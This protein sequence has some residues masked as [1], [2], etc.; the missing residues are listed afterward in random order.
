MLI[1]IPSHA[2]EQILRLSTDQSGLAISS[3]LRAADFCLSQ[4][5]LTVKVTFKM[6]PPHTTPQP[7]TFGESSFDC[8]NNDWGSSFQVGFDSSFDSGAM[9]DYRS[10]Q[11]QLKSRWS[12][13]K[14]APSES[15]QLTLKCRRR[16]RMFDS[17]SEARPKSPTSG[18]KAANCCSN[19]GSDQTLTCSRSANEAPRYQSVEAWCV[20]EMLKFSVVLQVQLNLANGFGIIWVLGVAKLPK[21]VSQSQVAT[22]YLFSPNLHSSL[23]KVAVLCN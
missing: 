13:H 6:P 8:I 23:P 3:A 10:D 17:E 20:G 2:D 22:K 15:C 12:T 11:Q 7:Q 4:H 21:N 1:A 19:Q 18:V 16:R 5:H 14:H 9:V